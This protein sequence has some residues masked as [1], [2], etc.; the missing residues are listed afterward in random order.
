MPQDSK[1]KI[2]VGSI[3]NCD[4]KKYKLRYQLKNKLYLMFL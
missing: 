1:T 3:L 4:F 2:L